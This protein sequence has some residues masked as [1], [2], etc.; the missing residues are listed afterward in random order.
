MIIQSKEDLQKVVNDYHDR[1]SR[2]S[3]NK[4]K[5]DAIEIL[6]GMATC[7]IAAG[8]QKVFDI[9]SKEIIDQNLHHVRIVPVGCMGYCHSEPTVV[10]T[11]AKKNPV[12]YG[13]VDAEMAL[14]I[15]DQ[16]I[17]NNKVVKSHVI[18]CEFERAI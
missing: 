17:V 15:L 14:Q 1:A 5:K 7:G 3:S 18:G 12:I 8:S 13:R 2:R 4:A 10:V 9:L 16:H 6:V 11:M